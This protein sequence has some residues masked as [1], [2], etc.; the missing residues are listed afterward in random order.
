VHLTDEEFDALHAQQYGLPVDHQLD[1]ATM[2]I[3]QQALA[4][5]KLW[6]SFSSH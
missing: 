2:S 4:I 3:E 6:D 5:L 1:V